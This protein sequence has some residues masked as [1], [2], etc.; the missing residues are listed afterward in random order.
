MSSIAASSPSPIVIVGAGVGGLVAA[1]ELSRSGR[2]VLVLERAACAGGKL[3]SIELAGVPIDAG[4]TVFTMRPLFEDIFAAGGQSLG[5][6]LALTPLAVLARH[7][8]SGGARLD[9]HADSAQTET[10]IGEF[11]GA[12][13]ARAYRRFHRD[14]RAIYAT[15]ERAYLLTEKPTPFSLAM[16][17]GWRRLPELWRIRPFATLWRALGDYFKDARLRQLFGRYATYV[18]SSP[19]SA[20]A[21]LMLIADVEQSGVWRVEGGMQRLSV[22]LE[23]LARAQG[24]RFRYSCEVQSIVSDN[25]RVCAVELAD[26]ERISTNTVLANADAAA[27]A[28]GHFGAAAARVAAPLP[29]AKRSLSAMTWVMRAQVSGFP[30]HH[31]TVFFGDD[32]AREFTDLFVERRLPRVPTVY[33]C[34]QDRGDATATP[35]AAESLFC[36]INAPADGD[37]RH[38]DRRIVEAATATMRARLADCGL[39]LAIDTTAVTT[40]ADFH[41]LFPAT[42]GALYGCAQ[43]GWRASFQRPPATTSLR[44]LY[45]AG[46]STHPGA[47]LPMA[48]ISGRLAAWR[49]ARDLGSRRP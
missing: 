35:G 45:L 10:A 2:E 25:G 8:W 43:H 16:R 5:A 37:S 1:G 46:G 27:L 29:A 36:L 26:G 22:A 6:E 24:A 49:I 34:A 30:L 42:G 21:T 4:P 20:P 19:F 7:A 14:A 17:L 28:A 12:G 32:Y 23:R 18:G 48:A 31:H 47:G 40:P 38:Y 39:T 33:I 11:A 3:R 15:L 13:E 9:L 41:A 44:G